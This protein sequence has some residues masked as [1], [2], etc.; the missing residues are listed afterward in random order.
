MTLCQVG[1]SEN[2]VICPE[3]WAQFDITSERILTGPDGDARDTISSEKTCMIWDERDY[4]IV[5]LP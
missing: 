5:E 4:L 2:V 1:L 3:H